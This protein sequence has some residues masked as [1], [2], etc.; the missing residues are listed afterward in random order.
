MKI[1]FADDDVE[2]RTIFNLSLVTIGGHEVHLAKDGVE[3]VRT[4][5][6]HDFD[7]VI[8]DLEMPLMDGWGAI[9]LIRQTEKGAHIPIV[10]L[11]AYY[12]TSLVKSIEK[13]KINMVLAKPIAPQLL[14]QIIEEAVWVFQ[15]SRPD[16]Q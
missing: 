10:V 5:N 12:T 4:F 7:V 9:S 14:M 16:K 6:S 2:T 13:E 8:M 3:A 11:T 1:L 15:H